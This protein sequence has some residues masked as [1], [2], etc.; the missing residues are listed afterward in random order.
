MIKV[1]YEYS[2]KKFEISPYNTGQEKEILLLG[3]ISTPT[4]D[5]ALQICGVENSVI[6]SLSEY[7]KIAMLYKFRTVSVGDDLNLKFTC[8]HCKTSSD[9]VINISDIIENSNITNPL[10][11][12]RYKKLTEDNFQEFIN[13]DIDDLEIDEYEKLF[14]E[15]EK[16]ITKF[17]FKKPIICQKCSKENFIS[18]EKPTFVIDNLSEDTIMSLY[19][20]YNDLTY[21]GK[22]TKQDIDTLYPFE[23]TI[24]ISLLNK[25]RE[26]LNK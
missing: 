1:P 24:L 19:Q 11:T 6:E 22:Y 14:A 3:M 2:D 4:L 18:I 20:T 21:F 5:G 16:S 26:D 13:K 23:R 9:N 7:E 25:T 15:T 12:D 17:N 10:I 8:K